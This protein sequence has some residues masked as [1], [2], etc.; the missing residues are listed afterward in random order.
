MPKTFRWLGILVLPFGLY[1][2]LIGA[3]ALPL[4]GDPRN[5]HAPLWV[6]L[7][8]GLVFVLAGC[9]TLMQTLGGAND[10]GELPSGAP[11]WLRTLQYL[12]GIVLF[13]S[14][15]LIGSWAAV[16]DQPVRLSHGFSLPAITDNA[17]TGRI[18]FGIGAVMTWLCT[19]AYAVTGWRKLTG[20]N[21]S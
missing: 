14:F 15:A 7:L 4:P 19:L 8:A 21:R 16:S 11:Q 1:L 6:V 10:S 5:L 2:M 12:A 18:A 9:A 17:I 3:G 20:S 13:A